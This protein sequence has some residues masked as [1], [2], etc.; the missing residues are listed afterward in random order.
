MKKVRRLS[1]KRSGISF[2][3][4]E[5]RRVGAA[6]FKAKCLELVDQVN[7]LGVEIIVTKHRR[8]VARVV[9][10]GGRQVGF[11]GSL[12]GAVLRYGDI[13]SPTGERWE[14]DES[15]LA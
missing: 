13:V 8:P 15:N 4:A 10:V 7:R 12:A 11:C 2:L 9:P 14:N 1:K 6:E 3:M 5:P